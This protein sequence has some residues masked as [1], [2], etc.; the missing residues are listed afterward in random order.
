MNRLRRYLVMF[1]IIICRNG[2]TRADYLRRKHYFKSIGKHVYLQPWNY[3]TEP[4]LISL[5]DN[6]HIASKVL[7]VNHDITS[8]MFN[9]MD[10]QNKYKLRQ[11]EINI[12]NNV[13]IGANT[14][15]LYDVSIG[16]NVIVGAGSLVNKHI[17]SG[18][19]VAGVPAKII[20]SFD[21]YKQ[22]MLIK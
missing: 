20:G 8:M 3:G 9:Y 14:T 21:E 12:G 19:V 4:Y 10:D 2:Y 13:F 16:D 6:V 5:G 15:I 17:P 22:K 7:F 18:T 1:R 11:G